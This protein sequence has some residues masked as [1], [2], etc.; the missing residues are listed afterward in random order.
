MSKIKRKRPKMNKTLIVW[1]I[2]YMCVLE[3]K[4]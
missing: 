1:K 4:V 3:T 2:A